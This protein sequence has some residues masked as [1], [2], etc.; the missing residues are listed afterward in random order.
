MTIVTG[1]ISKS[2]F[3]QYPIRI[4]IFRFRFDI[5][6]IVVNVRIGLILLLGGLGGL[7]QGCV[8]DRT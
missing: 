8:G 7:G 4:V 1:I 3:G 2:P 5:A 6:C